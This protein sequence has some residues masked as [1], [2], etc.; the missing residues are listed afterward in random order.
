MEGVVSGGGV[1][2]LRAELR[3][4]ETTM[5][6]AD[7]AAAAAAIRTYGRLEERLAVLGGDAAESP[8]PSITASLGLPHPVPHP[9]LR[10]PSRGGRRPVEPGPIPFSAPPSPLLVTP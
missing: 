2:Q 7:S 3:A 6:D 1:E 10:P 5:A 4:G 9:P 8:A